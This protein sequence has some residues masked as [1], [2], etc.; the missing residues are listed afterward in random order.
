MRRAT[1]V[2]VFSFALSSSAFAATVVAQDGDA[3]ISRD[4]SGAWTLGA[5]GASLTLIADI[6]RDFAVNQLVSPSGVVWTIGSA[7]DSGFRVHGQLVSFGARAD[8]FSFRSVSTSSNSPR[9]QLDASYDLTSANLQVTR[10]Y[11]I[12]SG[13][14]TFETWTT[15][16][17]ADGS[18]IADLSALQVSLPA[19][20]LHWV[21]GL[22]G[23][24]ADVE[25]D[26]AFTRK[27]QMLGV[28]SSLALGATG[29]ASEQI[30]PWFAIDGPKD[31]FYAALMW[32]GAWS[33]SAA[34]SAS[35]LRITLGLPPMST[36]VRNSVDGA[37]V[38]FGVAAGALPE[39]TAA[40]RSYVL[41]GIRGGRPLQPFVTYNTWFAYGTEIDEETLKAEM[42]REAALGVELFVVD[43]GW[44]EGAGA[45]G[46]F[47]FDAGLGSWTPDPAR[48]PNGLR[49]L[50]D[51]AHSLG[52]QFGVWV[53]P[54]R[55]NL[56][57]V[58]APGI[59]EAWLATTGGNY[60][61]DHAAQICLSVAAA[62]QYILD[63]LTE[64]VD[65]VQPDYLKWDNNMWVNCDRDGHDHGATDGNFAQVRGLYQVLSAL[66]DQYPN[67]L[68]ENV[69]GG[70][71]RLDLG[72]L[73]YTDAAWMDDRTAPSVHVRHNIEGLSAM[74]PPAY[75]LSFVTDH[76]TEPLHDSPDLS[77]YFRSRMAG[78]LGLCFRSDGLSE[79][80]L[81]GIAHEIDIY[82]AM[83]G[84]QS[85]A[86]AAL[87]T[88]QAQPD[89]GPAWDVLQESASGDAQ[90]LLCA[91]QSDQGTNTI[92]VKPTGLIPDA[93][94][95]VQSVDTGSLGT[96]TGAAL[97]AD[98]IQL[99]Q[100]PNTAAHILL[101][102]VQ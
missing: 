74:F 43:A 34:R 91:Y 41:A 89:Q 96:A 92:T 35:E 57:L 93:S 50:R 19:G 99:V 58:G 61:S 18:T 51:H 90:S 23:D 82:K 80:D 46:P 71:N 65:A 63:R 101:L 67:L 81:A 56:S 7:A 12:V 4:D 28:G 27:Q 20:A 55:V 86:A 73:R 54:E 60:G 62:R 42:D 75:L 97:M 10:H 48:F 21:T 49:P 15:Y 52:M 94:Y 87:L 8:G 22:Q 83:R 84:T 13:S 88:P 70:G 69:S 5:G 30:V 11:A 29:R 79:S 98:G 72:M 2:V 24:N 76:D 37:H 9:L 40:L 6:G 100:S 39:A 59:E 66:R 25:S 26:S 102:R 3:N 77:L 38:V 33:L 17:S 47:D 68:I 16:A 44:Y 36:T 53:E 45:S 14:P 32:S 85:A 95:E 1:F 78:A 64:L 31:E